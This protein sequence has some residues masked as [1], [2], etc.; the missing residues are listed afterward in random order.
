MPFDSEKILGARDVAVQAALHVA[1]R[2][3]EN[4]GKIE[5]RQKDDDMGPVTELDLWA[6]SEIKKV[7]TQY[8]RSFGFFGEEYGLE[9]SKETYWV[10]DPIDGTRQ[11]VRGIPFCAT[12]IALIHKNDIL[13][14][15]IYH[16]TT[17]EMYTA[18]KGGGA[19]LND[20]P[21][22][23]SNRPLEKSTVDVSVNLDDDKGI[24]L[25]CSVGQR[26]IALCRYNCSAYT[27]TM[28]ASGRIEGRVWLGRKGGPWDHAPGAL[29][30]K[31][32]GGVV[33]HADGSDYDAN[34][35]DSF[36]AGT[37]ELVDFALS[38]IA[39]IGLTK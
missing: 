35:T 1:P 36:I 15:V 31:E 12:M 28:T 39:K 20:K 32:A 6:E 2:L 30:I 11:Y 24:R 7:L 33:K 38:E 19:Y 21:I 16:F 34:R 18:T 37:Q 4:F 17:D 23:I 25:L 13:A 10:I 8:D 29:L 3:K 5:A 14:S 9:G 27:N 22:R 26:T